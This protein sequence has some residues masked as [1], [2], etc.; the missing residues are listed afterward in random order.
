M[1]AAVGAAGASLALAPEAPGI[2]AWLAIGA[3]VLFGVATLAG[4]RRQAI[5]VAAIAATAVAARLAVAPGDADIPTSLPDGSGPWRAVVETISAPRDGQQVATLAIDA[6]PGDDRLRVAAT[7][8]RY[9]S[10]QPG[11]RVV[12]GG[13]LDTPPEGPYGDYLRRIGVAATLRSRTLEVVAPT[14]PAA[15]LES[16]RRGAASALAAAIPEPEAGLAAGI[17]VGLRDRVDRDLAADFTTVGASHVVAISGWNIAIVA[18]SVAAL[19]GRL[20]RRRR[21]VLTI[22]A[23]GVYVVFVGA[24][25]SVLRAAAMAGVVLLAR[26][27]GRAGQA[28]AALGWAATLLLLAEPSLVRDA[29]FQLSTLATGGL[30]AWATPVS[31]RLESVGRGHLPGW[32][33]EGLGV[34]L[35]AQAATLPVVLASFGR[36]SLVSPAVNLMVVPL[37]AP[38]MAAG[39]VALVAGAATVA[40]G[41]PSVIATLAGLPAWALLALVVTVVRLAAA[42]PFAS[43]AV[44]PP[45]GLMLGAVMT[46]LLLTGGTTTGRR[47]LRRAGGSRSRAAPGTR[48]RNGPASRTPPRARLPRIAA[49]ALAGSVAVT[50]LALA[51]HPDGRTRIVVLDVGQGDAILVEGSRGGRIL[52]DGGPDPDALLVALDERLPPWDRRVDA[53]VLTHPHEDHVAGLA[54]LLDRYHVGRVVEPGMRGPGPGYRAWTEGLAS[55]GIRSTALATGDRLR[56]DDARLRVLWPD[57]G[58]VDPDPADTGTGI[59]NVSIVLL[60]EVDGRRFLLAGDIEEEIDPTL[61]ERGLPAVDVL[62]VAHHGSATATTDAFLDAVRPPVAVVSAGEGNRYGHPALGTLDRLAARD[63]RI[64]RTDRDGT[65]EIALAREGVTVRTSGRRAA[66]SVAVRAGGDDTMAATQA[67]RRVAA[68][69]LV[70]P[71][72]CGIPAD[73]G[74]TAPADVD[75]ELT[76][77]PG[78]GADGIA[79]AVR[80][81][82]ASA[83]PDRPRLPGVVAGLLYHRRDVGPRARRRRPPSPDSRSPELV[84]APLARGRGDRRVA[85]RPHRGARDVGRSPPCRNSCPPA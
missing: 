82:T 38:A 76:G 23:I 16:L 40:I 3:S 35:A 7:L 51:H 50:G 84:H 41:V 63:S 33:V 9:P 65:V 68:P 12:A 30:I 52:V 13:S 62:K 64:L 59:N 4:A 2:V 48:S 83:G 70:R 27:S 31:H 21:S 74:S 24:S 66:A 85:R 75:D 26:E 57:P 32:L 77:P 15:A 25:A 36:L 10:V 45:G 71:I 5:L 72:L 14:G 69:S 55:L 79:A 58:S 80:P 20:A 73:A 17:L 56:V 11:H 81:Q 1:A 78:A 37:I 22:A 28:K 46:V 47:W 54:M 29:G 42:V 60:G 44:E 43:V 61:V 49:I 8:P 6:A 53:L 19:G 34:S 18:A 39:A 67:S